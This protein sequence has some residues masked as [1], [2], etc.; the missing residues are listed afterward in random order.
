LFF[1]LHFFHRKKRRKR[2]RIGGRERVT[3][4]LFSKLKNVFFDT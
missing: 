2:A 3:G 1:V 4:A